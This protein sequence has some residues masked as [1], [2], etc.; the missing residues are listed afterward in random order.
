MRNKFAGVFLMNETLSAH[1]ARSASPAALRKNDAA[2]VP[3]AGVK[4]AAAE[5][6]DV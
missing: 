3:R 5:V 4:F 6:L 2:T 1:G